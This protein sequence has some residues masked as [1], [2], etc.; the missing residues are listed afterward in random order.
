MLSLG[1]LGSHDG[2]YFN[3]L[4]DEVEIFDRALSAVEIAAIYN[5]GSAGKCRS[6]APVPSGM[7]AW[8]KAEDNA[9]DLIGTNDGNLQGGVTYAA[10]KVGQAFSFS[11]D[12]AMVTIP[13]HT[14]LLLDSNQAA[15]FDGWFRSTGGDGMV[16]GKHSAGIGWFFTTGQGCYFGDHH[17]GGSGVG[18]LNIN[19]GLFHHFACV[20]D[21]TTYREYIDGVLLAEDTGPN[22]GTPDY[23]PVE[24][25]R[26]E[27]GAQLTGIVDE[28]EVFHRAL[29]TPEIQAIYNAGSAGKCNIDVNPDSFSFTNQTGAERNTLIESNAIPVLGIDYAAPISITGGSYKVSTDGGTTFS[30]CSATTPASVNLNDQVK[31]CLTASPSFLTTTSAT[32]TIGTVSGTFTVTT[33]AQSADLSITKTSAPVAPIVGQPLTYTLTVTN[34]GPDE[35]EGVTVTD[36]LA[37]SLAFDSATGCTYNSGNRTVTC[38]LGSVG[39]GTGNQK[40]VEIIVI[41]TVPGPVSNAAS[42]STT[43]SDP[44]SS[45]NLSPTDQTTVFAQ[46]YLPLILRN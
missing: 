28:L 25:G 30:D 24:I 3:G 43:V 23:G 40:S 5:A 32:L 11:V 42:V 19:D 7:V 17:I 18:G 36:V 44:N 38:D 35:A 14:T 16:I 33:R 12:G 13:H 39:V 20:K 1:R 4:I 9:L 15:T 6:C 27:F 34:T 10:G 22:A 31:V 26:Y 37:A 8:W 21:G 29:S 2:F 46:L 45:N 41:P